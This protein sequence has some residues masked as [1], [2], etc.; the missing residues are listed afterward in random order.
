[1]GSSFGQL[2]HIT[3]FGESHGGGVGVVIDGCPPRI[4]LSELHIQREL[5]RR[6]D[7]ACLGSGASGGL[8]TPTLSTG[9][10][11][12]AAAG[13]AWS[14]AW[15]GSPVGAYA[16]VG[17]SAMMGAAMQAPLTAL[18]LIVELTAGGYSL[19]VPMIAAT[20]TATVVA[21]Q[22]DGYSIYTARLRAR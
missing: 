11:L 22:I 12:G 20:V 7:A 10:A 13:I 2:F 18:A 8:F 4:S 21:R 5:D 16:L 15:P 1:M 14:A 19:L 3:T 17:A 9:A 6:G